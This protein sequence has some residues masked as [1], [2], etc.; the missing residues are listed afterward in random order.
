MKGEN[1]FDEAY[2]EEILHNKFHYDFSARLIC[3][4]KTTGPSELRATGFLNNIYEITRSSSLPINTEIT[5]YFCQE[6]KT[7]FNS[8]T[9]LIPHPVPPTVGV[10]GKSSKH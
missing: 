6:K 2:L 10:F 9:S 5:A 1:Y 7:I 4:L 3:L 8:I